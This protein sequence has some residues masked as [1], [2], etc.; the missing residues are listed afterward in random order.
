[1]KLTSLMLRRCVTWP[2]CSP[3]VCS[4]CLDREVSLSRSTHYSTM[5]HPRPRVLI[6]ILRRD[7]RL[8][9]NP[10][11]H[12]ASLQCS[13]QEG[14][15]K[16]PQ[17][18]ITRHREDSVFS[19]Q[20]DVPA[21]THLLPV[22]VFPANQVEVSGFIPNTTDRSPYPQARSRIAGVWRTGA[23]RAKFMAEG[24]WD[25]K[26]RLEGLGCGSGLHARVGLIGEVVKEMLDWYARESEDDG[27]KVDVAGVWMTAEEGTEEKDDEADV[28]RIT[29]ERGVD[30]KVWEDEKYYIDECVQSLYYHIGA[31]Y[32]VPRADT[33]QSRFTLR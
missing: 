23:H 10:V 4:D 2:L 20:Q 25:L 33:R 32:E 8:S 30:F 3:P 31:T 16:S 26:E 9:D 17:S 27:D 24:F 21:F 6:Y 18:T 14:R 29:G 7:V 15:A 22:Y 5:A 11:F 19:Q 12:Q 13:E 1:M 28:K